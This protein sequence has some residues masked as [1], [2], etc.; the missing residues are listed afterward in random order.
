M[1]STEITFSVAK[2]ILTDIIQRI[3]CVELNLLPVE[4]TQM[5][6]EKTRSNILWC[7]HVMEY[8]V[9]I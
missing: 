2:L 3:P 7:I 8:N 6:T 9:V 4:T 1:P 5:P